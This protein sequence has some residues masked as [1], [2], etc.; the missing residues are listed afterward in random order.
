MDTYVIL[1]AAGVT[2]FYFFSTRA[3]PLSQKPNPGRSF[4]DD[5]N[6]ITAMVNSKRPYSMREANEAGLKTKLARFLLVHAA[7]EM[8]ASISD[9]EDDDDTELVATA[10]MAML[11]QAC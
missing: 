2:A 11:M 1:L 7:A 8:T 10:S 5:P 9:D 6:D 3:F 4:R